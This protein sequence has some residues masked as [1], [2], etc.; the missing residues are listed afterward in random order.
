MNSCGDRVG[1]GAA[2]VWHTGTCNG[3]QSADA[4]IG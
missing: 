2:G 3:P 4:G 1:I